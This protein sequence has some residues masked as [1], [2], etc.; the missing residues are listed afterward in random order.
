MITR[1]AFT[2]PDGDLVVELHRGSVQVSGAYAAL[3]GTYPGPAGVVMAT[4]ATSIGD[5]HR[6]LSGAQELAALRERFARALADG[7]EEARAIDQETIAKLELRIGFLRVEP[8][9]ESAP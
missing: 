2:L 6:M 1:Y 9:G 5:M 7:I 3:N 4:L 8:A